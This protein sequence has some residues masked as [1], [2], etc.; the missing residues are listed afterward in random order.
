[1]M[2]LLM[3]LMMLSATQ[4]GGFGP[5]Q[6]S[7]QAGEVQQL[8][9]GLPIKLKASMLNVLRMLGQPSQWVSLQQNS[10]EPQTLEHVQMTKGRPTL[11]LL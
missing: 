10:S 4:P 1:M 6:P 11:L 7:Q 5:H 8:R 3:I 9:E 2:H